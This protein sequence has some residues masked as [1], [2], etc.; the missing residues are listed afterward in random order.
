MTIEVRVPA[1]PESVADATLVT[2]HKQPGEHV[3]RD[4]NLAD[5]E[6]DKVVLEVPAPV[7]GVLVEV[8]C[9]SD[10]VESRAVLRPNTACW[11]TSRTL[12]SAFFDSFGRRL[13]R[14][15]RIAPNHVFAKAVR[16]EPRVLE[17]PETGRE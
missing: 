14:S 13:L 8:N 2:W 10:F 1:L 4:E 12:A 15:P 6:T 7:A 3:S 17:P 16:H 11:V 5:L 9:E